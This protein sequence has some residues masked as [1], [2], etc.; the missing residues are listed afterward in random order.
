MERDKENR[1]LD[2]DGDTKEKMWILPKLQFYPDE[3]YKEQLSFN[4]LS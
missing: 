1:M 4:N 3:H 2:A